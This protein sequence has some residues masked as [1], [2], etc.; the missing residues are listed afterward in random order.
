LGALEVADGLAVGKPAFFAELLQ[1]FVADLTAIFVIFNAAFDQAFPLGE[2]KGG[3][4]GDALFVLVDAAWFE[5]LALTILVEEEGL[6][7]LGAD[8]VLVVNAVDVLFVALTVGCQVFVGF[9]D[10]ADFS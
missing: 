3:L 7:A 4:A 1:P 5:G 9:A 2:G 6:A 10:E 8:S